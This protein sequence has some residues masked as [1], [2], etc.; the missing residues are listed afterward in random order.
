MRTTYDSGREIFPLGED[1]QGWLLY[2]PDGYMAAFLSRA[3]RPAFETGEMLSAD[4]AEKV[5]AWD[6]FFSYCGR[7]E[8]RGNEVVH[9]VESSIYPN[10]IGDAQARTMRL[11][12]DRLILTTPPQKTRRGVQTSEVVWRR[13]VR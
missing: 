1:A 11:E 10:W 4:D 3:N 12:G 5:R 2:T 9:H 7:Y 13:A 8:V 6:S